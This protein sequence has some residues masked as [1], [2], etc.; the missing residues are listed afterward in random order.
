MTKLTNY[1]RNGKGRG[2]LMALYISIALAFTT[3]IASFIFIQHI[4]STPEA[5]SFINEFPVLTLKDGAIQDD[6]IWARPIHLT[7]NMTLTVVLD[8][9]R[10]NV[11][12]PLDPGIYI[13]RSTLT[14]F[15]GD[16]ANQ[17]MFKD[18]DVSFSL[19]DQVE[20]L[21]SQMPVA[22]AVATF[23]I[24][25]LGFLLTVL[26]SSLLAWLARIHTSAGRAWRVSLAVFTSFAVISVIV[27]VAAA[28]FYMLL[29]FGF[30]PL[31]AL[32]AIVSTIIL[33][34]LQEKEI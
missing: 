15:D 19:K 10:D 1:L 22:A 16:I 25:W 8:T 7:K 21:R 11:T 5:Q 26:L 14:T 27:F 29:V 17:Y 31:V 18:Q 32:S 2:L 23:V 28:F 3:A 30:Y 13:T 4:T 33:Y 6:V 20:N 12:L 34:F 9:S 24:F